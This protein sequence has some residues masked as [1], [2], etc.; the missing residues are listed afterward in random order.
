MS[1]AIYF[2]PAA[3]SEDQYNQSLQ[4]LEAD[5]SFPAD[6]MLHHSCFG[7]PD[8]LMVYEVWESQE[9]LDAF[10]ARLMPI[11]QELGIDPGQPS[12]MAV[13]NL[14]QQ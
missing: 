1:V 13:V 6:G 10:G 3:L 4:R 7:E 2:S 9:K 8:H 14:Q 11:L 12:V 5:G